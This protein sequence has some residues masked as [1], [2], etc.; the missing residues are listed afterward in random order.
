MISRKD[1]KEQISSEMANIVDGPEGQISQV[2]LTR[3]F[4][5]KSAL[6]E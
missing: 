4:V 5:I 2:V 6:L 3:T 1:A